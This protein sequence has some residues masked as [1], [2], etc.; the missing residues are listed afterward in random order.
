MDEKNA[1]ERARETNEKIAQG[2]TGAIQGKDVRQGDIYFHVLDAIKDTEAQA[3]K[4]ALLRAAREI[5]LSVASPN[6]HLSKEHET[7][8]NMRRKGA[9]EAIGVIEKLMEDE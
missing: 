2:I 1:E 8:D 9:Y 7:E 3:R 6:W 4:E 5:A